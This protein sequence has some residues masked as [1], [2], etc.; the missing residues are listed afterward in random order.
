MVRFPVAPLSNC[1]TASPVQ[2]SDHDSLQHPPQPSTGQLRSWFGCPAGVLTPHVPAFRAP[3]AAD[4]ELQHYGSPSQR[5]VR[6]ATLHGPS[7]GPFAAAA[8]APPV[9][10]HNPARHQPLPSGLEAKFV[11]SAEGGQVRGR[12]SQHQFPVTLTGRSFVDVSTPTPRPDTRL[13]LPS[14]MPSRQCRYRWSIP[15]PRCGTG[16]RAV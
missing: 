7:R 2:V 8:S 16:S 1:D 6:Q 5:F 3:P 15:R 4:R 9:R 12:R 11:E 10:F 13:G 14:T